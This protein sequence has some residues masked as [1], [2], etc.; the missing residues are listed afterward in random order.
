MKQ[1]RDI[2]A[3]VTVICAVTLL[4]NGQTQKATAIFRQIWLSSNITLCAVNKKNSSLSCYN[5]RWPLL[6][7]FCS[8]C[9]LPYSFTAYRHRR[10]LQNLLPIVV[11]CMRRAFVVVVLIIAFVVT[12]VVIDFRIA[13]NNS[14]NR[15]S[16]NRSCCRQASSFTN[17]LDNRSYQR[18][19]CCRSHIDSYW[20]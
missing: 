13:R 7:V 6:R 20:W 11:N 19:F 10:L 3:Y 1:R 17:R 5:A 18:R 12:V 8:F 16:S 14:N 15:A 2:R 9:C 4:A